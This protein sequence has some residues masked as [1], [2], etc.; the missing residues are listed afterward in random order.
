MRYFLVMLKLKLQPWMQLRD[1]IN[2]APT[3]F[4]KSELLI[5]TNAKSA[6]I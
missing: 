2:V 5:F 6:S 4:L 1:T 3:A